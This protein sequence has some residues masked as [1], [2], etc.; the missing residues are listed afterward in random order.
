MV[1]ECGISMSSGTGARLY[2]GIGR[3]F[4]SHALSRRVYLGKG[5]C[6]KHRRPTNRTARALNRGFEKEVNISTQS[7]SGMI[8]QTDRL[9]RAG[10]VPAGTTT[11]VSSFCVANLNNAPSIV[12]ASLPLRYNVTEPTPHGLR[13]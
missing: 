9:N 3:G 13:S 7:T 1:F 12:S 2:I 11:R 8:S 10:V 4:S 6:Y 5:Q